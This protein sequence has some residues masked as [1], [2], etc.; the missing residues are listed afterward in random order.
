MIRTGQGGDF[1]E[2]E[3]ESLLHQ[4]SSCS[5][6]SVVSLSF[7]LS[8]DFQEVRPGIKGHPDSVGE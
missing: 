7:S 2:G 4:R 5:L 6:P 8:Y 3:R 1:S